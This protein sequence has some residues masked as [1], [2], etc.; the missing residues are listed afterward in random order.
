MELLV[1]SHVF[2]PLVFPTFV[3]SAAVIRPALV[4]SARGMVASVP[5]SLVTRPLVGLAM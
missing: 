4:P 5:V 1:S 3:F 2:V